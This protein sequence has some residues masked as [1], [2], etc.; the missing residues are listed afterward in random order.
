MQKKQHDLAGIDGNMLLSS[1]WEELL[2]PDW[3]MTMPM[4]KESQ[5]AKKGEE[6]GLAEKSDQEASLKAEEAD[7][8]TEQHPIRFEDAVRRKFTLPFHTAKTWQGWK[9]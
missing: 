8:R 9:R 1:S 3:S 7:V 4:R 6:A 2:Q 5:D